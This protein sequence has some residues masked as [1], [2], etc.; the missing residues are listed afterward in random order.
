MPE[1]KKNLST[2]EKIAKAKKLATEIKELCLSE[3]ELSSIAGGGEGGC[4]KVSHAE[5]IR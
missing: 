4:W 2:E 3:Q 1:E 5:V